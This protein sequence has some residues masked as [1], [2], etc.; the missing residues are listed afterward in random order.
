MTTYKSRPGPYGKQRENGE[1][2]S[3]E[4]R[5]QSDLQMGQLI[6]EVKNIGITLTTMQTDIKGLQ[7]YMHTNKGYFS[8]LRSGVHLGLLVIAGG[9]GAAGRE[10]LSK[11]AG[12][13]Q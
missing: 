1:A 2:M 9:V 4:L 12:W 13:F 8:G 3:E 10:I 11:V 6:Q 7:E 5:R